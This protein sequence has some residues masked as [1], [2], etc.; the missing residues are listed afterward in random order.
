MRWAPILGDFEI[1]EDAIIFHGKEL[2]PRP[3]AQ[4]EAPNPAPAAP[5]PMLGILVSD[6]P[7]GDGTFSAEIEFGGPLA[8]LTVA[9]LI[10]HYSVET[11][12]QLAAGLGSDGNA[13]GIRDW[14]SA[15]GSGEPNRW[16][17]LDVLG[18]RMQLRPGQKYA[19]EASLR[20]SRVTLSVDGVNV[21]SALLR[22][23]LP[24]RGQVG[25]FCVA[26]SDVIFRNVRIQMVRSKAFVVMQYSSPFNEIYS[27]VIKQAC[28]DYGLDPVR[29]DEIQGPGMIVRDITEEILH[30]QVVIADVTPSNQN[31]YFEVGYAYGVQKPTILLAEKGAKLPFDLAGFRTLFYENSI[32]GRAHFD[33]GIRRHL[34][35]IVGE[36]K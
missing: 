25:L 17:S 33:E 27:D 13:Y 2:P 18:D 5:N 3:E 4:A 12:A 32:A 14:T 9:E 28:K 24:E 1:R 31:V 29:A 30:S 22:R 36:A 26:S 16:I 23:V 6:Q 35:A 8:P 19:I 10:L 15:A 20:G 21:A 7:A 11:K 34:A